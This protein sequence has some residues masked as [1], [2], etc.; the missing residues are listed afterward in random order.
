MANPC[1]CPSISSSSPF[2]VTP[3]VLLNQKNI[4][5]LFKTVIFSPG[6]AVMSAF[7]LL[8]D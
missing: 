4:P 8:P 6:A 1:I 2:E 7:S 5:L 3:K